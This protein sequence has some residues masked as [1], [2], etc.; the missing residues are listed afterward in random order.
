[1]PQNDHGINTPPRASRHGPQPFLPP[2]LPPCPRV[3]A[4]P[5]LL[6]PDA[7]G[8]E[9]PEEAQLVIPSGARNLLLALHHGSRNTGNGTRPFAFRLS[10]FAVPSGAFLRALCVNPSD[11]RRPP[12]PLRASLRALCVIAF[13][14]PCSLLGSR[15]TANPGCAPSASTKPNSPCRAPTL[16]AQPLF[17][18]RFVGR[19]FNRDIKSEKPEGL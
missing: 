16:P 1:M 18:T 19:G 14:F 3:S 12:R 13:L 2:R 7:P 9:A 8:R 15:G 4:L 5:R 11:S 10:P 6:R 17:S